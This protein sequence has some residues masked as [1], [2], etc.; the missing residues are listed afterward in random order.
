MTLFSF[1]QAM[2]LTFLDDTDG[3]PSDL[4]LLSLLIIFLNFPFIPF[5]PPKTVLRSTDGFGPRTWAELAFFEWDRASLPC[6]MEM[7]A[8]TPRW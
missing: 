8:F 2:V 1:T 5:F 3:S 7:S 6:Y 4:S